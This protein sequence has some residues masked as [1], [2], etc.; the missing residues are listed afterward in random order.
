MKLKNFIP[1]HRPNKS[2]DTARSTSALT[3]HSIP[4]MNFHQLMDSVVKNPRYCKG[5]VLRHVGRSRV[6]FGSCFSPVSFHLHSLGERCTCAA[7]WQ[8]IFV[9]DA[10]FI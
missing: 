8:F 6:L 5:N 1:T 10:Y 4:Q 7:R 9:C 2:N 3:S